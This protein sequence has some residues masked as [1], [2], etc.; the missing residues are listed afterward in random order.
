MGRPAG[1]FMTVIIDDEGAGA[2]NGDADGGRLRVE[3]PRGRQPGGSAC[4]SVRAIH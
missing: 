3:I 4:T 1:Q 2:R